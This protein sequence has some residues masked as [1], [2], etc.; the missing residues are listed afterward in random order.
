MQ[1]LIRMKHSIKRVTGGAK[2]R[3]FDKM[4]EKKKRGGEKEK[5]GGGGDCSHRLFPSPLLHV[6]IRVYA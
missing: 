6:R 5:R 4:D 2:E 3:Q 1:C